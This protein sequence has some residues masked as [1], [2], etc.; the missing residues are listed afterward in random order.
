MIRIP[1]VVTTVPAGGF[2]LMDTVNVRLEAVYGTVDSPT[3]GVD[4]IV[5]TRH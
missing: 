2:K 4:N 3:S 5:R 1:A